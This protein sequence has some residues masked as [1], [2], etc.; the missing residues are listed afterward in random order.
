MQIMVPEG[1]IN[2]NRFVAPD[3]RFFVPDVP[4]IGI[5]SVVDDIARE[6]YEGRVGIRDRL[7]QGN[8]YGRIRCLCIFRVVKASVTVRDEV[9][10]RFDVEM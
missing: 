8:S 3:A 5:D 4:V 2:R 7:D 10:G 6:T 1:R 9:E